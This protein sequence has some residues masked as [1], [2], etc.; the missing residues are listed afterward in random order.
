M[1]FNQLSTLQTRLETSDKI[2]K[3][4]N[5]M[6]SEFQIS[7]ENCKYKLLYIFNSIPYSVDY[8]TVNEIVQNVI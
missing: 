6:K 5:S 1:S 4:I 3:Y 2:A 7:Q 8:E